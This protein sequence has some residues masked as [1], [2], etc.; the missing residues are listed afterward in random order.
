MILEK[1]KYIKINGFDTLYSPFYWE[2][3]DLSYRAWKA[4]YEVYF[5]TNIVVEHHH[6]S[7]IATHFSKRQIHI[8][9]YRNQ[10]ITIWKN[11]SDSVYINEHVLYLIKNCILSPFKNE[12]ELLM[13]FLKAIFMLPLILEKRRN[14][15][16]MWL[17]SDRNIFNKFKT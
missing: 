17:K 7:T 15:K 16:K 4:G 14:Q 1:E 3:I 11:I 13:G 9:S 10:L 12:S 8:I 5:D 2:D 6:E